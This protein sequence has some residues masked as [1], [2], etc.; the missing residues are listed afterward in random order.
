MARITSGIGNAATK[1]MVLVFGLFARN[2]AGYVA[3]FI[4]AAKVGA[5]VG[6]GFKTGAVQ[7][8][9]IREFFCYVNGGV[10][11]TEAGGEDDFVALCGKLVD[12][13]LGVGAFGLPIP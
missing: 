2:N 1:P 6:R 5:N 12:N 10:H 9:N 4:H 11:I 3:R 8:G 7:E 13:T